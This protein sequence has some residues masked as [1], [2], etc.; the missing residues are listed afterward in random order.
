MACFRIHVLHVSFKPITSSLSSS[1][2]NTERKYCHRARQV[3]VWL[4]QPTGDRTRSSD[5]SHTISIISFRSYPHPG[6][7]FGSQTAGVPTADYRKPLPCR[8][9]MEIEH[10]KKKV[11]EGQLLRMQCE[12]AAEDTARVL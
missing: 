5:P 1:T 2:S 6:R 7:D 8:D 11:D 10:L 9:K 12:A 3:C 4:K